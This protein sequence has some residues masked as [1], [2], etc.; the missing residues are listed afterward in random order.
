MYEAMTRRR[1]LGLTGGAATAAVLGLALDACGSSA[2]GQATT[3][4]PTSTRT[5]TTSHLPPISVPVAVA[6]WTPAFTAIV[7]RYTKETGHQVHTSTYP[8]SGLLTQQTNAMLHNSKQFD[9]LMLNTGW[10]GEFFD[11]GWVVPIHEMDQSFKWPSALIEYGG[12][13][14]WD[15]AHKVTSPTG[16]PMA[17]PMLGN[18]QLFF[19]RKD[20][21]N[22]LGLKVPTTW[23]EVW[24]NG[25][26]AMKAGLVRYG[27]AI[28]GQADIGGYANTFDFGGILGSYGGSWFADAQ[29]GDF[30]P[31]INDA[32]GQEAMAEWIRLGK[33]GP[34]T[35]QTVG[36]SEIQA[37]MQ[38]GQLLQTELVD[39]SYAPMDNASQSRVVDK[40]DYAVLPAGTGGGATHSPLSGIW[41]LGVP[42]GLAKDHQTAAYQFMSWLTQPTNQLPYA[43][44]GGIPTLQSV[45]NSGLAKEKKFR[46]MSAVSAST[47]YVRSG[48]TYT[49]AVPMTNI[50]EATISEI[51]AG[52]VSVRA[53]LDKIAEGLKRVAKP[54]S[55]S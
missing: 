38:S 29:K 15:A 9:L 41:A 2:P 44:A 36:Q 23:D 19:Y 46:Y 7:A 53:G 25:K 8:F 39:A 45:Y 27:Y 37:L 14:R 50:T 20:L 18:I 6:P 52:Q 1:F 10:M 5:S 24:S 51:V 55:S 47:P 35:P 42:A 54:G 21:Y 49:F 34:A 32:R 28:R 33:L 30:T 16:E 31:A 17:L 48:I 4:S 40:V 26:A 43:K 3:K 22:K 12:C 13:C 11:R